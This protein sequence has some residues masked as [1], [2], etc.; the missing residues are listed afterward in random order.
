MLV[1]VV[2]QRVPSSSNAHHHV[3][4]QDPHENQHLGVSDPVF[5]FG[6]ADHG[7]LRRT[8]A[9]LDQVSNLQ[10]QGKKIFQTSVRNDRQSLK[11]L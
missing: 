11:E 9:S 7:E 4:P 2:A 8:R 1:Q 10:Q 3:A 5:A 6:H